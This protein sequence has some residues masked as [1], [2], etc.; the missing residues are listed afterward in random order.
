MHI[1]NIPTISATNKLN[2]KNKSPEKYTHL[3]NL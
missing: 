2:G 3:Q 1:A